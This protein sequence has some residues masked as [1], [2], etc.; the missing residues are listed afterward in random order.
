MDVAGVLLA[1]KFG[2]RHPKLVTMLLYGASAYRGFLA[3][4]NEIR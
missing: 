3:A 2:K 1:H 4:R